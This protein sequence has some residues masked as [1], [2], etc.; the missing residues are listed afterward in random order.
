M[1][2]ISR[3]PILAIG[4]SYAAHGSNAAILARCWRTSDVASCEDV[5]RQP[6][7]ISKP[8][9]EED[10]WGESRG[11]PRSRATNSPGER[12]IPDQP[13]TAAGSAATTDT[14]SSPPVFAQ[15]ASVSRNLRRQPNNCCGANHAGDSADGISARGNLRDDPNFVLVPVNTST[16]C[17]GLVLAS[18]SVT[19]LNLVADTSPQALRS[20]HHSQGD[21]GTPLTV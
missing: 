19:I 7:I 14:N 10:G 11:G 3:K 2:D 20:R 8:E 18:S 6:M 5:V 16:R 13:P 21:A 9:P 15:A 4:A 17:A 12:H 1:T